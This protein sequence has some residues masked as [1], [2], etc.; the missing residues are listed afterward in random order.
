METK[1]TE[2]VRK[3]QGHQEHLNRLQS[4][5]EHQ[6]EE[7]V[8]MTHDKLTEQYRLQIAQLEARHK[9]EVE[10]LLEVSQR[11]CLR[12]F[13]YTQDS[14]SVHSFNFVSVFVAHVVAFHPV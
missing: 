4:G 13:Q 3:E 12:I 5:L 1:N 6:L 2:L 7:A 11:E 8:Q 14:A 9:A 10:R